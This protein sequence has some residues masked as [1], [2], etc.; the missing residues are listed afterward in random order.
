VNNFFKIVLFF[1]FITNCS[2][3]KNSKFWTKQEIVKEKQEKKINQKNVTE[4]FNKKEN[5]INEFNPNLKISLYSKAIDKSFLNNFDNNNGRI[6]FNGNLQSVSKYKFSKIKNFHQYDPK[7]SIYGND[8]IFFDNKGSI[9]RF[10]NDTDLVWKRNNY[11]K[12]EKKQNPI[13]FFA[14]NK[15]TLI[16]A[17][18]I[19]KYYALDINTGEILWSKNNVA[20]FNSE[21]KIYKDKFF[22]IDFENVL[23]AY[24]VSNGN[25][26]WN[27]R[28]TNLLIRSQKNLSMVIIKD[29]IYFNNSSGD[30]SSVDIQ[31]GELLW[32][33]PTQSSLVYGE[34]FFLKT[35][36][37]IADKDTIYFSNNKNKFFSLDI[38]TGTLNW[39][40][41][42]NSNLRPTLIDNY[43]FTVSLDGYL[44]II[45][46]N[47]GNIIRITDSFKNFKIKNR[48]K[49]KPTGFIVGK[50]NVYLSTNHGRLLILDIETGKVLDILKIDNAKITRPLILNQNMFI[51]TDNSII[52]LN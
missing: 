16:V 10:N 35:S 31:T 12:S 51:I 24:S 8:I 49:I 45:E 47:S 7:I 21:I 50:D 17:D 41:K 38:R 20:P 43:I 32:Q 5:L 23:R 39:E 4:I 34:S 25:E 42:V 19:S 30:I 14:N 6:D 29:K 13:L 27:V 33:T 1:I 44:I 9:L 46:K 28:T 3:H 2:L 11:I 52:K 40:Q 18:N 22:V 36:D 15:K 26:I 37:I 48:N